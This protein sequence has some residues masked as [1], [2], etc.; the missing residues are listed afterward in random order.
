MS[1][2]N[3]FPCG[4]AVSC[5]MSK[6]LCIVLSRQTRTLGKKI[7]SFLCLQLVKLV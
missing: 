5:N 7:K 4:A 2:Q 1:A 6:G 3:L